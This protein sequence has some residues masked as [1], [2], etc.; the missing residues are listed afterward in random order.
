MDSTDV[1]NEDVADVFAIPAD[2]IYGLAQNEALAAIDAKTMAANVGGFS[3]Y[4]AGLGG[5]FAI[6]GE[7]LAF[8]M[9]IETLIT[10]V[11]TANAEAKGIDITQPI[12]M[13]D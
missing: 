1:T 10:F 6:D 11:N 4:D 2:R 8:P 5:N 7:Y 9:N 3:D 13:S 12:E